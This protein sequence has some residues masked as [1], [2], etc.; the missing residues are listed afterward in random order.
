MRVALCLSGQARGIDLGWELFKKNIIE[1]NKCDVFVSFANDSSLNRLKNIKDFKYTEIE[2]TKDPGLEYLYRIARGDALYIKHLGDMSKECTNLA[3]L[4][5]HYFVN[6][7]NKMKK[8]YEDRNNFVYDW[9]VRS[10][11]DLIIETKLD[12]LSNRDINNIYIPASD[13]SGGLNDFFAFG[14]SK[15]IDVYSDRINEINKL[16]DNMFPFHNPHMELQYILDKNKIPVK[17]IDFKVKREKVWRGEGSLNL[18]RYYGEHGEPTAK[19]R[20]RSINKGKK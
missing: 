4:R 20:T 19:S 17:K 16:S 14:S 11:A 9:V 6:R 13:S 3:V 10:R 18:L 2:L 12:D 8:D 15:N 5:Q 1:P 7:A